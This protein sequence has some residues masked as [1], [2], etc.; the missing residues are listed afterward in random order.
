MQLYSLRL[1]ALGLVCGAVLAV[2]ASCSGATAPAPQAGA[3]GL[4]VDV[5]WADT[6]PGGLPTV[7]FRVTNSAGS[8]KEYVGV[9]C[10]FLLNGRT[11]TS[12][13][14]F[15][16]DISTG[17]TVYGIAWSEEKSA[18]FDSARCSVSGGRDVR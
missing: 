7:R 12:V 2:T 6:G 5:D 13:D 16:G 18:R 8:A 1:G 3:S 14:W 17:E 15:V 4:S 10:A 9:S 11:Q